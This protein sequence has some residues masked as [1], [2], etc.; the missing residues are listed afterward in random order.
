MMII[1]RVKTSKGRC[2][3]WKVEG[4]KTAICGGSGLFETCGEEL[5]MCLCCLRREAKYRTG[6]A[7]QGS[8]NF[9]SVVSLVPLRREAIGKDYIAYRL[10]EAANGSDR[11]GTGKRASPVRN[12]ALS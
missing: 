10:R 1:S 11:T 7:E 12:G 5:R 2:A 6:V 8:K 3:H 9:D 4:R